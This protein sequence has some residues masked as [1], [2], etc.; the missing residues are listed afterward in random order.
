MPDVYNSEWYAQVASPEYARHYAED[1]SFL[2]EITTRGVASSIYGYPG[3]IGIP[4]CDLK[5]LRNEVG[6]PLFIRHH[7]NWEPRPWDTVI[8]RK[9][10]VVPLDQPWEDKE[11]T[12]AF[13]KGIKASYLG[14]DRRALQVF[15]ESYLRAMDRKVAGPKYR[16]IVDRL[17]LWAGNAQVHVFEAPGAGA[18]FLSGKEWAHYH[19]SY[20]EP[21]AHGTAMHA[22]FSCAVPIM[23]KLGCRRIHL[24][25]GVTAAD[26]D[27]LYLFKS[28]LGKVEH[29]VYFQEVP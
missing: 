24:G 29:T 6:R 21:E 5:A 28:R 8:R 15:R 22:V 9:T 27:P 20:R 1:A 25:G 3:I 11:G 2:H 16:H 14:S 18:L 19:L 10:R 17:A 4:T 7:L 12:R 26:D 23:T 13:R